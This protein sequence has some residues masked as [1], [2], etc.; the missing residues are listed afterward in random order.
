VIRE[1]PII[2]KSTGGATAQLLGLTN[3]IYV[4]QKTGRPFI[5]RHFLYSTGTFWKF[6]IG[7]LLSAS[8]IEVSSYPDS[9]LIDDFQ[10]GEPL[11]QAPPNE[12]GK[13]RKKIL[14]LVHLLGLN[15]Q[16]RRFR[17]E[18]VVGGKRHVLDLAT[19]NTKSIS[20]I[21][22]PVLAPQVR[23]E[24]SRRFELANKPNPF[25]KPTNIHEVVIHYRLGDMRKVPSRIEGI[26]GHG[27]VDPMTFKRILDQVNPSLSNTRLTL[28]SD[29]P[30]LASELLNE[31]GLEVSGSLNIQNFWQDLKIISEARIFIGSLS[32][33]SSFGAMACASNGGKCFLPSDVYGSGDTQKDF[34]IDVFNY[35]DYSYLKSNHWLFN[36]P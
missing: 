30:I 34:A 29:E 23:S 32:Q 17:K 12:T 9:D 2:V 4:S 21:F 18:L 22:V 13:I 19:H 15:S 14:Q 5:F 31:V 27:V 16:I 35:F 28:V 33:F 36:R 6:E 1:T 7:D 10:N 3:A 20:G 11:N 24:L 25:A 8:E 26:G